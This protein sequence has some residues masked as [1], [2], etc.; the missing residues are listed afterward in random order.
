MTE[1]HTVIFQPSGRRG[2]VPHGTS[3]RAAGRALGVDIESICAENSTCG[4]CKVL[5]QEGTFDR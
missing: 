4:K 3:V 2:Q 1:Q 5:I